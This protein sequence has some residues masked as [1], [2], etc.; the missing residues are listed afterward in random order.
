M[1]LANELEVALAEKRYYRDRVALL[2]AKQYRWGVGPSPRLR[3]LEREL[4]R[5][6]QRLSEVRSRQAR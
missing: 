3:Q 1:S 2:R 4:Q 6:T 5:A